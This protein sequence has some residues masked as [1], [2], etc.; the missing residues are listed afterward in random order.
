MLL[1]LSLLVERV[2]LCS[3]DIIALKLMCQLVWLLLQ[4]LSL[5]SCLLVHLVFLVKLLFLWSNGYLFDLLRLLNHVT[6]YYRSEHWWALLT[7]ILMTG[8]KW[9]FCCNFIGKNIAESLP[10]IIETLTNPPLYLSLYSLLSLPF[11]FLF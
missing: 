1:N 7:S 10:L 9:V 8:L 11:F 5:S 6:V 3:L 2:S 4:N